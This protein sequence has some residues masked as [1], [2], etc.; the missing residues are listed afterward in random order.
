MVDLLDFED[1]QR[2]IQANPMVLELLAFYTVGGKPAWLPKRKLETVIPKEETRLHTLALG[3]CWLEPGAGNP[4]LPHE[5][6]QQACYRLTRS[7]RAIL[8]EAL[9]ASP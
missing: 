2:F 8:Q 4:E 9:A 1:D 5:L 6:S 3:A 7:G